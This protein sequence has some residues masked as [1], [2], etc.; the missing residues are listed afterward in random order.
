[1]PASSR[2]GPLL[3][4][5]HY[6]VWL[7]FGI[8]EHFTPRI[9]SAIQTAVKDG[10][11]LLSVMSV[12]ELGMLEFKGRIRL[13]IPCEQWVKEALAM[14]GLTLVP[15]TPEIAIESTRLPGN[16]RA[17]P[18]DRIIVATARRMRARL[19]TRDEK[20]LR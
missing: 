18:A 9:D 20:L 15:L 7:Q 13:D 1:M 8:K 10:N 16:L 5:T 6:W 3:L 17:D 19:L 4:D 2:G 11:L 14:P 12:W